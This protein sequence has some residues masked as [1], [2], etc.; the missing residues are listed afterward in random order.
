MAIENK[1]VLD[2]KQWL[3]EYFARYQRALFGSDVYGQLIRL[4][5]ILVATRDAGKKVI[6]AGNGGSAAMASHCAVD[7]TKSAGVRSINFNEADLITCLS[8]DY[9]YENWL[10]RALGFYADP[11]DV[12]I[13]ISSSGKSPNMVRAAR[14]ASSR[15]LMV[16]TLT[17]F[18]ERNPLKLVGDLN[19]WVESSAYNVIEMTHHIW[20]LAVCDLIIGKAE[21]PASA[22][23]A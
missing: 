10:E 2:E 12:I 14:Y 23:P 5:E 17:G 19:F 9:G 21:Y 11:G 16:V 22:P 13:L 1:P 20:L 6:I 4:K 3:S 18:D 15:G 7:F 8:N